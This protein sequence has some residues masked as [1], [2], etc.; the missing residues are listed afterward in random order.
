MNKLDELESKSIYIIREAYHQFKDIAALWSI[1]KDSTTL[2]HLCRKAFYG[3]VPFPLMHIDTSYKF[4]EMYRFRDEY[5]KKWGM[6]LIVTRNEEAIAAGMGPNV[7]EKL[8]C[9][10]QL[11][12]NALKLGIAQNG[13]KALLLGIRRDEHG[14]RA[15]ERYFSPATRISSG[16]T[17]T[18]PR[19]SGTNINQR[20]KMRNTSAS[21]RFCTGPSWTSGNTSSGKICPSP[22]CISPRTASASGPSAAY[23]AALRSIPKPT[24]STRSSKN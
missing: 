10:T 11:K 6:K 3:E 22:I 9:C 18:S 5:A 1:G 21:I 7:G 14:I 17:R 13:F 2:V 8:E 12:T 23:P 19:N 4:P 20:R 16:I 24:R 15:K